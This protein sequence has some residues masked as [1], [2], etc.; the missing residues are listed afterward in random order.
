MGLEIDYTKA[1]EFKAHRIQIDE[2]LSAT[3]HTHAEDWNLSLLDSF[4]G[5]PDISF[6]EDEFLTG[7]AKFKHEDL[8]D[9][10]TH[11]ELTE[12]LEAQGY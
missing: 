10:P 1:D 9:Y 7:F 6:D 5:M 8:Y 12:F 2:I 4:D 3:L 11:A